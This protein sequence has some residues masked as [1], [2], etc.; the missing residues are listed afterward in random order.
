MSD[1]QESTG[2]PTAKRARP[3]RAGEKQ[4]PLKAEP[5]SYVAMHEVNAAMCLAGGILSPRF[6]ESAARDHHVAGSGLQI[7]PLAPSAQALA[8]AKGDL[9]YGNVVLFEVPPPV[10]GEPS[11]P[12]LPLLRATRLV[13]E[14]PEARDM[15]RARMSGYGDVPGDVLPMEVD[16]NL[17][18]MRSAALQAALLGSAV[19][20]NGTTEA[21]QA[22]VVHDAAAS[23]AFRAIDRSAGGLLGAVST[24]HGSSAVRLIEALGRLS[25]GKPGGSSVEQIGS[26]IALLA[27]PSPEASTFA[28][29]LSAAITVL[30]SG[31][32]DD[33]FSAKSFLREAE[34]ASGKGMQEGSPQQQ[35][36]QRFWAFTKEVL[37]LRREVPEGAWSDEGGSAIA[38]G[39]LLFML[40]PEPEQ[41]QA[42]RDRTPSLGAAVHFISGMLVGIR[43]GLTRMGREVKSAREPF[44]AGAAFVHDW[45][46][47]QDATLTLRWTWDAEDG[48]RG[49]VLA[50]EGNAIA[51]VKEL[52]DRS[53]VA[54]VT[55]LRATGIDVHFSPDTGD[56][57]GRLGTA[58]PEATFT[59]VDATLP[60]FPR[61][62]ALEV[63][64]F[65][66]VKLARRAA[67]ALVAEVN[68]GTRGHCVS[69]QLIEEPSRRAAL[70]LSVFVLK[71]ASGDPLKE[72]IAA[73]VSKASGVAPPAP[74]KTPRRAA[75]G[76]RT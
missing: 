31:A 76:K 6:E 35:A 11:P 44:L 28:P 75:A 68:G 56:L 47:G 62:P 49:G 24:L 8:G 7:E 39:T 57:S 43:S 27:D 64:V 40:N 71:P 70:R 67:E 45:L 59:A 10:P 14:S 9:P 65:V 58:G 60:A 42:V 2:K 36:I 46:R 51:R 48:S 23:R 3:S 53:R 30:A 63:S 15:F 50:Y 12:S 73:L 66:P 72:A 4:R 74:T 19:V 54:L 41:L 18:A 69:A 25:L 21:A 22:E 33:G 52:A 16:A 34:P 37:D 5:R 1:A 55:T 61:Q 38:R 29:V 17:F 20:A 26:A 32:M 13:F